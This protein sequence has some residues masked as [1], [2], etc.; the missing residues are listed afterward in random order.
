[1][2]RRLETGHWP[3]VH[4]VLLVAL[5]SAAAFLL[6]VVLLRL[7]VHSLAIR[8]GVAA[9][10]GYAAFV[11][12]I[13]AWVRWK[14]SRL[15]KDLTNKV[16]DSAID[17]PL[18]SLPSPSAET[19]TSIFT[20][21]RSGGAGA[22]ANWSAPR[23][24]V[25]PSGSPSSGVSKGSGFSLDFDADD[26]IWVLL[27]LA[28]AFAGFL[29]VAYVI[30]VAPTL[31]AEAAVNAAIAGKVYRGMRK[32]ESQHWTTQVLRRTAVSA[33]VLILSATAAGYALQR[34]APEARSIGGVW[35]HLT[36][37]AQ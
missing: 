31:L 17:V 2:R 5:A 26:L 30:Y 27:A 35:T 20:G 25:A 14:W 28:A 34:I 16:V 1:M 18:Q 9:A 13:R 37:R 32:R 12:L 6:S 4:C 23:A 7:Q 24:V 21:G 8:Y 29:A 36:E 15:A 22:S 11:L 19:S 10:A 33:I 3:R